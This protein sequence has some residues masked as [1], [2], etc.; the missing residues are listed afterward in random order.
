MST[1][2]DNDNDH[3]IFQFDPH[4]CLD[5]SPTCAETHFAL[6]DNVSDLSNTPHR[7]HCLA[8][9]EDTHLAGSA[10]K[11][12][13]V[14]KPLPILPMH[15]NNSDIDS[16]S[17]AASS[18][19][20]SLS[21]LVNSLSSQLSV[22][23]FNYN[24]LISQDRNP[25]E[26]MYAR[27]Y[28][29]LDGGKGK[30]KETSS[31][32]T[33]PVF[34]LA[35]PDYGSLTHSVWSPP[36]L[37]TSGPSNHNS[38]SYPTVSLTTPPSSQVYPTSISPASSSSQHSQADLFA[39]KR[40]PSRCHSL[41]NLGTP[42][43]SMLK[44]KA[45]WNA[46]RFQHSLSRTFPFKRRDLVKVQLDTGPVTDSVVDVFDTF[47]PRYPDGAFL[48]MQLGGMPVASSDQ[49]L[50]RLKPRSNS[51]PEPMLA[52]DY[53][54]ISSLDIYE[55]IPLVIKNYFDD[56]L[57]T[58]L[59][60]NVFKSLLELHELDFQCLI[61]NEKWSMSK[62][63]S[64]KSQWVGKAKGVRELFKLSRVSKSWQKLV[65][66]GQLWKSIDLH[67]FPALPEA[68]LLR[69]SEFGC[70]FTRSLNLAGHF[71]V[72]ASTVI[73]IADNLCI[74]PRIMTS[75]Q[76]T[77][78]NLQGCPSLTTHSL[79]HLLILS[80]SLQILNV[81]GLSAVTNA[82][83]IILSIYCPLVVSLNM[84][85]CPNVDAE[86]I[87]Y[88]AS[89][90]LRKGEHLKLK[91]LRI[92]GLRKVSDGMMSTLGKAAPYLEVLDLS[93]AR[94][95]HNSALE[96]FIKCDTNDKAEVLG[97]KIATISARE[98][99]RESGNKDFHRRRVTRLRHL[100]LSHCVLLTDMACSNLAYSVPR[101]EFFEMAGI[102]ADLKDD[103]LIR[104]FRTTPYIRRIDL[105]DASDITD[106]V[107]EE[108]SPYP[109]HIEAQAKGSRITCKPGHAL[110]HLILSHAN[111]ISDEALLCLIQN[112]PRLRC[113]EADNTRM[114]AAVLR[115][116][117]QSRR[118]RKILKAKIVA[119][120]CRGVSDSLV[121]ELSESIRPRMGWRSYA[122][123][124]LMYLDARDDNAE[125]LKIGQDECDEKRVVVKSFY[126][127]QIVDFV[128]IARE[129]R[130]RSMKRVTSNSSDYED[131]TRRTRWW[132]PGGR[133]L[134]NSG[135]DT[136][137]NITDMNGNDGCLL[138]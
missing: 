73:S 136:P 89:A 122:A 123:R 131:S 28:Q 125:Y 118:E 135:R 62:A 92:S 66:D 138:M 106:R 29:S 74:P 15:S 102:G 113:L 76:L 56:E 55:S 79:H 44:V 112:C 13:D 126:T 17:L 88:M 35:G 43:R 50:S 57:P 100:S 6:H 94:H 20:S 103:G 115:E 21:P 63:A 80:E 108:I 93:Y 75:T 5:P 137:Q 1:P 134:S 3:S 8:T 51:L 24:H 121:K 16:V 109:V 53:I 7:D 25:E 71:Q 40:V 9:E 59:R 31:F 46:S 52:Q 48:C 127:W 86:G 105:E 18:A 129:K 83:C 61:A 133:R 128:H 132:S 10:D 12:K 39:S 117:V 99:G 97:V 19:E 107:L 124:K 32:L 114:G 27:I 14:S 67:E 81:K 26:E 42:S 49:S 69:L 54:P 58:E 110:E 47:V 60:L 11:G 120:D 90:S 96:E 4:T 116:F 101:L 36:S 65:F 37:P 104:L 2:H 22:S 119:V 111:Q 78:I 41:S 82:T 34:N 38:P 77:S 98:A 95:L 64:S 72:H 91:S 84:S 87:R 68:T 130:R 30:E 23:P 70:S 85:R 33:H 45:K